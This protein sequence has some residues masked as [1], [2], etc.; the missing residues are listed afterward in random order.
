MSDTCNRM[1]FSPLRA[2]VHGIS[3]TTILQADSL[4][5]ELQGK[6]YVCVYVYI[7]VCMCI[8]MR[9][10]VYI[11]SY[12]YIYIYIYLYINSVQFSHSVV[13]DSATPRTEAHQ[14]SL[15]ITNSQSLL[16]FMSVES[17]MPSNH[18]I[19]SLPFSSCLQSFPA[20]GCFTMS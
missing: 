4:P 6:P 9:V 5:T 8:Y 14:A 2:S 16:K 10:F 13:S 3:Q 18:L 20:S 12:I 7:Y 15:S 1:D 17:M 19:F 11:Y